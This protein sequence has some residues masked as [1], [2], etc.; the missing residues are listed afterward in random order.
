MKRLLLLLTISSAIFLNISVSPSQDDTDLLKD[1]AQNPPIKT[2]LDNGLIA[3]LKEVP[4]SGLVSIDARVKAGSAYEG[5]FSGSGISHLVEHMIFKGTPKRGPAMIEKEIRTLGGTINGATTHDYTT[6]TITIPKEHISYALDVLSDSLFNANMHPKELQKERDVI[7]KEIR[8]NRDDPMR[9]ISRLLWSTVF[10]KHPYRHPIIGYEALF[11]KLTRDDLSKYH[12]KMYVPNNIIL[13]LVGDIGQKEMLN[14]INKH[15]QHIERTPFEEKALPQ[16]KPQATK[17]T[18]DISLEL[19]M[20]YFALG[21]RSVDGL[22]PD[23]PALDIL[24]VILGQGQSSRLNANIYRNKNLVYSIGAWNHTPHDPGI[25]IISGVTEPEKLR[26]AL[27]AIGEEINNIKKGDIDEDE[28]KRAKAMISSEYIYSLQ[29]LSDQARDLATN[30]VFTGDFDFTKKYLEKINAVT[31]DEVGRVAKLY[32]NDSSLSV[33]TLSP[34]SKE[35]ISKEKEKSAQKNIEKF[36]LPNGLRFLL[37]EER[38]LPTV[39]MIAVCQ[40]GL[41]AEQE[42]TCGISNLTSLMM[43]KGTSSKSEEDISKMIEMMGADLAYFS[44][45]N[46]FGIRL[47]LLKRDIDKSLEL[48][49]DIIVNPSF[50]DDILQREKN[51]VM[52][53]IKAID[54]DI[55]NKGMKIFQETLFKIHPYRFQTIGRIDS[56]KNLTKDD[57]SE[58][59]KSYFIPNNMVLAIYGDIHAQGLKDWIEK[60]FSILKKRPTPKFTSV[61]EPDQTQIRQNLK[62]I[63]KEQSLVIMGFKGATIRGKDRYTLQLI[64]AVLSGISGRLSARLREDLGTAYAV[65]SLSVPGVDPGYFALYAATT[66]VNIERTKIEFLRQI[67]L[68]NKKGL[69]KDEIDSAKKELIGNQRIALQS[70]SSLAYQ[71]ALDE[72]YGLGY[73]NYLQYPKIMNSITRKDVID[74]SRKYLKPNAFTL[75]IIEG[76]R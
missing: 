1:V 73:D 58:F 6:F 57:L 51:S 74:A 44:G 39:S 33:I 68:L 62:T 70:N 71:S 2:I 66:S 75:I 17:R 16:E 42:A 13:A 23:M 67:E 19:E 76:K 25:F 5:E 63:Q 65:G 15:F 41:R 7:L 20:A 43:L 53:A 64:S 37:M 36:T 3:I 4:S 54:D 40:G 46:T 22:D 47:D 21:Y 9:H 56:V 69:T 28:L 8:L 48:F 11:R 18:Q 61:I 59:H 24:S 29:T 45:N 14:E 10:D 27:G 30:E 34:P 31:A 72:I 35:A 50:P 52:A 12:K 49:N 60:N 38:S 26:P 32:L 55:F